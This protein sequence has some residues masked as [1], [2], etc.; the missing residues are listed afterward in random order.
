[1]YGFCESTYIVIKLSLINVRPKCRDMRKKH[2]MYIECLGVWEISTSKSW[3]PRIPGG[4]KIPKSY[5]KKRVKP[6]LSGGSNDS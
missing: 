4:L 1:M 3:D 5:E 2:S 6:L